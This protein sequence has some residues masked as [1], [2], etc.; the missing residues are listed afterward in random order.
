[1]RVIAVTSK[2]GTYPT[3]RLRG[4]L[5]SFIDEPAPFEHDSIEQFYQ[6]KILPKIAEPAGVGPLHTDVRLRGPIARVGVATDG[7]RGPGGVDVRE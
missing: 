3:L 4:I 6:T 2:A 7:G 5:N 1:M